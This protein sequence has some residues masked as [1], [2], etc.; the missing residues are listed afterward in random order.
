MKIRL[1]LA[2]VENMK[3]TYIIEDLVTSDK[4]KSNSFVLVIYIY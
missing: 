3:F 4:S 2:C 1:I